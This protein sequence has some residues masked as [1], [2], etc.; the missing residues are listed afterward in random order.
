MIKRDSNKLEKYKSNYLF[1]LRYE[2]LVTGCANN[3]C[4]KDQ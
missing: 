3:I 1:G 2:K 4:L